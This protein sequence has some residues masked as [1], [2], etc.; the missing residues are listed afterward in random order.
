VP[1]RAL[2]IAGT[3][4][5]FWIAGGIRTG[6]GDRDLSVVGWSLFLVGHLIE[7]SGVIF[8]SVVGL[9]RQRA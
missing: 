4:L 1:R 3:V 9:L 2:A 5:E 7:I 8:V 6:T